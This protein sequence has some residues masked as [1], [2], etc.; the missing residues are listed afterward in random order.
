MYVTFWTHNDITRF[1]HLPYPLDLFPEHLWLFPK[2]K[3]CY[4]QE[5]SEE[6]IEGSQCIWDLEKLKVQPGLSMGA[7]I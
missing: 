7:F 3:I 2:I 5:Y 4:H 1:I 6:Y